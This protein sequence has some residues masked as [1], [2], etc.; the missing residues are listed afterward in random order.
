M[1]LY[2]RI[3]KIFGKSNLHSK[4]IFDENKKI[5]NKEIFHEIENK[6]L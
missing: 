3:V 5:E 4:K 1:S 2:K 6:K